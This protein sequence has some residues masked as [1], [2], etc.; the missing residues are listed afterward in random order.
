MSVARRIVARMNVILIAGF[1]LR[2]D[3]WSEVVP[4]LEQAGLTAHTPTLAGLESVD[5][6]RS[7][8]TLASQIAEVVALVDSLEG[9]GKVVL[10]GH[11]GGGAIIHGVVD[12]RPDRIERAVY[13]DS[14]PTPE[15]VAINEGLEATGADAP[16][17]P[18]EDFD[19][20]DLRDLTDEQLAWFRE[21]A[22]PEPA[23][24]AH[25]PQHLANP[26]RNEVPITLI[27]STFS[28]A[29]IEEAIA[30]GVPYFTEVP[31]MARATIV[32]LPTG[33]WP[34]FTKPRE[35]GRLIVQAV[36]T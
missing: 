20:T 23:R 5:D 17:P 34:Q 36:G 14:G 9:D 22:V 4:V 35:L 12:A 31:L 26:A 24:V 21:I 15:G 30:A 8:V 2:G 11:S 7:Q 33:H 16:L 6:D 19:E 28:R 27:S 29:E 13:V 1:W 18:W 32:E 3:S 10:V 25:D